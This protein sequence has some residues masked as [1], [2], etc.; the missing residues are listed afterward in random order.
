MADA[1]RARLSHD[2]KGRF[3]SSKEVERRINL[4]KSSID[5]SPSRDE[6]LCV[7][8]GS[9]I[10]GRRVVELELLAEA[11]D[12]GCKVCA[13]PLQ[14]SNVTDET[15]SGLGS[16]LYI[17]C[18]NPDCGEINVCQTNKTHRVAGTMRGRPIFDVN[19]K[20]AAGMLHAGMGPT[21]VN[22]LLSSL[23]IPTLCVTTLKAREREIGPAIE[24][25]ANKSCDLEMEEEKMEWGCIQD[26]AVPIGA[27]YDMGWQKRGK[28]HNNLT[29]AGS[30]IGIK[31]G[32]VIAFAT[33]SKRCATCEAATRAGRTA[34]AHDCRCN[35][36]GSSKAMEADVC[37]E[38]VK[39][40]GESH[41][42]QVAI[43][44]GDDDSST[45]K[46]VR[47]SVN[48]NVDKWS[49]IVHAKRAFG[50]SMYNL[51]KTHKNVSGKVLDYLQKCFNYAITQKKMTL[52]GSEKA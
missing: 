20:L 15:V 26:Q 48:H 34:R 13:K 36:D 35:W 25:I 4:A 43:L 33:R 1:K 41:K 8:N 6:A 29:G 5:K 31:T 14:L 51:Q 23:N 39:A 46:K 52:M 12:G 40:C 37:T 19:T 11:L 30:M 42:A 49:D 21:H 47:E 44:V 9:K 10:S 38:L 24:N 3:R 27:S 7:Q 32:K 2:K 22:A 50:S 45:I 28:G 17:T 16:F 18:C